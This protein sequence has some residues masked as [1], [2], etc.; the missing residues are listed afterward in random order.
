MR[1]K[2]ISIFC[3]ILFIYQGL[4]LIGS[5]LVLMSELRFSEFKAIEGD[6][7]ISNAVIALTVP[8]AFYGILASTLSLVSVYGLWKMKRW[9][10]YL[11]TAIIA[12]GI[13]FSYSMKL[14]FLIIGVPSFLAVYL[15]IAPLMGRKTIPANWS[16]QKIAILFSIFSIFSITSAIY[17]LNPLAFF[18]V[19]LGIKLNAKK[20]RGYYKMINIILK[21]VGVIFIIVFVVALYYMSEIYYPGRPGSHWIF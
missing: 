14:E 18:A 19:A 16:E 9:G 11:F 15:F 2:Y 8:A 4:A 13:F 20:E 3:I 17:F 7:S 1:P 10:V 12:V 21:I 6:D 5:I